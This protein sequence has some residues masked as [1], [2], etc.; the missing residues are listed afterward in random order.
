MVFYMD[1]E[2]LEIQW[3]KNKNLQI[4]TM[5][6]MKLCLNLKQMLSN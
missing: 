5:N 4:Q 1:L 3:F 6:P 2:A